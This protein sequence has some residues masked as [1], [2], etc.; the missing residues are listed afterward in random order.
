MSY[1][2]LEQ[3]RKKYNVNT[4]AEVYALRGIELKIN[5]GVFVSIVGPSGSGKSTL[6]HILGCIDTATE[7]RY[8]MQDKD[9][10]QINNKE[11]ASIRNKKLG[12]VLQEFGLILNNTSIDNVS[13][14]L[15]FS[16][17]KLRDIKNIAYDTLKKVGIEEL[18][19]K[20]VSQLS[21]GQ[22]QRVAIAR[23]L[24]NNPEIILADEPTGSLD[25]NTS[26]EIMKLLMELNKEERTVIIVTHNM[27]IAKMCNRII[28]IKDGKVVE[29]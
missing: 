7:G 21:G 6:L 11:L 1:I 18:A 22:R 29:D 20:K 16:K 12:F 26:M 9:L 28:T 25:E 13:I 3:I 17:T 10:S 19:Y 2:S 23:A 8:T 14:P 15:M 4:T 27:D 5:K 24:V